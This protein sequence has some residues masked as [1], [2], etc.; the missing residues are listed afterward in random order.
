[1]GQGTGTARFRGPFG[2]SIRRTLRV[3]GGGWRLLRAVDLAADA[4]E[5]L[6]E[7]LAEAVGAIA[8]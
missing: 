5:L 3:D 1:M 2:N 4:L 8:V 7:A 6:G